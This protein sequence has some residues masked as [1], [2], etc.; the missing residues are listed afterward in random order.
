MAITKKNRS[1][2]DI[3]FILTNN[4]AV[5]SKYTNTESTNNTA[6][7][8]EGCSDA[9]S[10]IERPNNAVGVEAYQIPPTTS[11]RKKTNTTAF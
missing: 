1:G 9:S 10:N 6:I 11:W 4:Q 2:P 8:I 5:K 3:P 7:I